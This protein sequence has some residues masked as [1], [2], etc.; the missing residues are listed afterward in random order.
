[1][2]NMAQNDTAKRDLIFWA[3]NHHRVDSGK[4]PQIDADTP[5][6]YFGYFQNE[7]GEQ[8]IFV[9]DYESHKGTLWMGDYGW[10]NPVGVIEG[11]APE[12]ML[13][14]EEQMWLRACWNAA[15]TFEAK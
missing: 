6:K 4:T 2:G 14:I 5:V 10:E 11:N 15:S 8:V 13:S 7:H 12:L 9:Y 1:M 3:S